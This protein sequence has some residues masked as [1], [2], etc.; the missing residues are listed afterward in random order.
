MV[1]DKKALKL[2]KGEKKARNDMPK[3]RNLPQAI[4]IYEDNNPQR[5]AEQLYQICKGNELKEVICW[6]QKYAESEE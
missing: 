6:L 3:H 4:I 5:K 2:S 1:I